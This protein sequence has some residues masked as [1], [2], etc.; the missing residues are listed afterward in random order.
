MVSYRSAR[1]PQLLKG[2]SESEDFGLTWASPP[3]READFRKVVNACAAWSAP[4]AAGGCCRF[5]WLVLRAS[6]SARPI[7]ATLAFHRTKGRATDL[8]PG[9]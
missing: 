5:P 1:S 7:R 3:R 8:S 4:I 2:C 6:G 9:T